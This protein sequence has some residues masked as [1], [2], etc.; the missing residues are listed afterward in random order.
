MEQGI[1]CSASKKIHIKTFFKKNQDVL[2]E[3]G[4]TAS[5]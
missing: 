1:S 4:N 2:I 5:T 3:W